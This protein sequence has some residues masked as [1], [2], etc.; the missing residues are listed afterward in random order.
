M[1]N[2][3]GCSLNC[4]LDEF[5]LN[6]NKSGPLTVLVIGLLTKHL[7][8][9][10]SVSYLSSHKFGVLILSVISDYYFIFMAK[11]LLLAAISLIH[12]PL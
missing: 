12:K 9:L 1:K 2:Y 10:I 5:N 7:A 6:V 11:P 8:G 4:P 3:N